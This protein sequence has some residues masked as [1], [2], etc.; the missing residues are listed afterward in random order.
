MK[1]ISQGKVLSIEVAQPPFADQKV[2]AGRVAVIRRMRSEVARHL[3]DLDTL[4]AS[5]QS[6]AFAGEL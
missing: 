1:N 6:R 3:S 4:F 5:L 2:F